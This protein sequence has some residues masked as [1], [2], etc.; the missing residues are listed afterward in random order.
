MTIH[1]QKRSVASAPPGTANIAWAGLTQT[2]P[3]LVPAFDPTTLA[4]L[5]EP[6]RRLLARALPVGTPLRPSVELE[7]TGRMRLRRWWLPFRARQ[8]LEAGSGFVWEPVVGRRLVRFE[9]AD[10]LTPAEA[11]MEFRAYGRI[12][13][14]SESGSDIARS[15]A[16]RLAAET[17]AWVPQALTPQLGAEWSPID[18]TTARVHVTA[19]GERIGVDVTVADDGRLE[20]LGLLRWGA[21]DGESPAWHRFGGVMTGEYATADEV[22]IAGEGAV[23]WWFGTDRWAEGE[24][25]RFGILSAQHPGAQAAQAWS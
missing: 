9:G 12:P 13:V 15:A 24:F 25:F 6:A 11:R 18:D 5:P 16:G 19:D 7:M 1:H 2:R 3:H 8:V 4:D 14:V 22:R 23:G 10:V 17:V 20:A 21:P